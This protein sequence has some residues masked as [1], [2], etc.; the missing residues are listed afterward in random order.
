MNRNGNDGDVSST[1]A[2]MPSASGDWSSPCAVIHLAS[3]K[4][5]TLR[6]SA[7]VKVPSSETGASGLA[8][9]RRRL[10][11]VAFD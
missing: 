7:G 8:S 4:S 10:R 5:A 11:I 3:P 2:E 1:L 6:I 9:Q